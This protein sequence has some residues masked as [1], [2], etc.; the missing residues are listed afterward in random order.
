MSTAL[1]T[2]SAPILFSRY[3]G[4]ILMVLCTLVMLNGCAPPDRPERPAADVSFDIDTSLAALGEKLY[5]DENLSNPPGQSCASCH[6]PSA[7]FA[8]PDQHF[9][10]SEGVV[11]SRFG[12]RNAPTGSYAAYIPEFSFEQNNNGGEFIGGQFLDGRASTLEDQAKAPFLN[13]LEMNMTDT[14]AVVDAVRDSEY[15]GEFE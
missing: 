14:N 15:A 6:L 3:H 8:D 4:K 5:F 1:Q 7:G 10:V 11:S 12:A 13:P 9:P 2:S